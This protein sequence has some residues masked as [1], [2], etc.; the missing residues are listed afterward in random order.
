VHIERVKTVVTTRIGP[1]IGYIDV[2]IWLEDA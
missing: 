2:R 1:V